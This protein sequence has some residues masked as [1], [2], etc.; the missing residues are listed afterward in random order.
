MRDGLRTGITGGYLVVGAAALAVSVAEMGRSPS[1]L[2][3]V[4]G[5]LLPALLA[6]GLVAAGLWLSFRSGLTT[7]EVRRV[8]VW[9]GLGMAA[10]G[11]FAVAFVLAGDGRYGVAEPALLVSETVVGGAFAGLVIGFYDVLSR[12]QR[13]QLRAER[14]RLDVLNRMLRHHLLNGMNIILASA[15]ELDRRSEAPSPELRTIR[16]RG[17]E[18]VG[19]V[20]RV[21]DLTDQIHRHPDPRPVPVARLLSAP[22]ARARAAYGTRNVELDEPLPDVAVLGDETLPEAVE[23]A[24]FERAGVGDRLVVDAV[25][26]TDEVV[27]RIHDRGRVPM[28]AADGGVGSDTAT[29]PT[30]DDVSLNQGVDLYMAELLLSRSGGRLETP[31]EGDG[32]V[33][34]LHLQRA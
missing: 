15:G 21:S 16:Q 2:A 17:D 1:T 26:E 18:V 3:L 13:A 20:E 19:L 23:M 27:I 22:V 33:V 24:V 30:S 7:P 10:L 12:R 5:G 8:A 31:T 11:T 9:S 4:F 32:A 25:A 29:A 6:V 14:E 28:T 34:E